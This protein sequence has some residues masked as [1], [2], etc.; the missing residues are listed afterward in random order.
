MLHLKPHLRFHFRELL[1]LYKKVDGVLGSGNE[2]A[3]K[4]TLKLHLR[5][6]LAVYIKTYKKVH[7]RLYLRLH[8]RVHLRLHLSCACITL[9]FAHINAQNYAK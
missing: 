1:K 3:P 9:V 7:L 2:S 5:L 8:L 4:G 6:H